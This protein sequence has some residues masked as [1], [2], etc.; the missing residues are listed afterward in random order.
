MTLAHAK[1]MYVFFK[2]CELCFL[3]TL[4]CGCKIDFFHASHNLFNSV[5]P[6]LYDFLSSVKPKSRYF[7]K[8]LFFSQKLF[9]DQH[10]SKYQREH[11]LKM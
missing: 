5:I 6:N 10:S 9:G 3:S 11:Y 1:K 4:P 7:E 8:C 2:I